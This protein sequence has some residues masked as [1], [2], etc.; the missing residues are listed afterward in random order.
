MH[1]YNDSKRLR[2][3]MD[4]QGGKKVTQSSHLLP[5]DFPN[6]SRS[7]ITLNEDKPRREGTSTRYNQN[8]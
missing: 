3:R 7:Q 1:I 2:F 8:P 4:F 5:L 6:V